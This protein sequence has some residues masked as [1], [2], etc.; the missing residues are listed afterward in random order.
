MFTDMAISADLNTKFSSYL[1]A[2][3]ERQ[4]THSIVLN[5]LAVRDVFTNE[6][7][8][9]QCNVVEYLYCAAQ[10]QQSL[11]INYLLPNLKFDLA[12]LSGTGPSIRKG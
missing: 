8:V 9:R 7:N 3:S 2:N 5:V 4:L 11:P 1:S 10:F 6:C 12:V